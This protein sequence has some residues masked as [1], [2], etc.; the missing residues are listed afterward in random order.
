MNIMID[1]ETLGTRH[2]AP[3]LQIA[4]QS[5][6]GNDPCVGVCSTYVDLVSA[7]KHGARIEPE[8]VIWWAGKPEAQAKMFTSAAVG[9]RMALLMLSAFVE[10]YKRP[11]IWAK[12]P[13]FDL[14]ILRSAMERLSIPCPWGFR[15]ERDVRTLLSISPVDKDNASPHDAV[16]DCADQVQQVRV[17][18]EKLGIVLE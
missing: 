17:A 15:Q 4:A 10:R 16:A 12:S 18:Y 2:D 8:T 14:V 6:D 11:Q 7:V 3:I 1:I 13:S 5:F 9:I